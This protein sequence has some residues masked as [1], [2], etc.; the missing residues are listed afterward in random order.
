[1]RAAVYDEQGFGGA[2]NHLAALGIPPESLGSLPA[3]AVPVRNPVLKAAAHTRT[4]TGEECYS[5]CMK[6]SRYLI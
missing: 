4:E 1:M 3:A 6:H 5:M 2:R